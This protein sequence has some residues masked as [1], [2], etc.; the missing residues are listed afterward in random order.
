[1]GEQGVAATRE[2][3]T[4]EALRRGDEQAFAQLVRRYHGSMLKVARAHVSTAAVA[5]EVVQEAWLGVLKGIGRF[6]GRSSLKTW[7]FRI[8][9]NTAKTRGVRERRTVPFSSLGPDEPAVA[10]DRFR[11]SDEAHAG[12]WTPAGIPVPWDEIPEVRIEAD[13]TFA[14]VRDTIN[15]LP[16]NQRAVITLRDIEGWRS[17][18]VREFLEVTEANQRVLLH[19]ARARVRRALEAH[20]QAPA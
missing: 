19:R 4:V 3:E 15:A 1:M 17:E 2:V 12:H 10:G 7:L 9:V 6:E 8:L 5:E 18:E 20:L 16:E 13:E 11:P 14:V